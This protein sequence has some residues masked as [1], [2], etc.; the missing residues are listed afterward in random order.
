MAYFKFKEL[1]KYFDFTGELDINS[2]PDYVKDYV[3]DD[4][5]III[6]YKTRRDK[7]V[8]TDKAIILFDLVPIG[9]K[10]KIHKVPYRSISSGAVSF[11]KRSATI[12]FSLDSGYQLCLTFINLTSAG[13]SNVRMLYTMIM[14]EVMNKWY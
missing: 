1:S 12:E 5:K 4:E 14:G 13:K 9:I 11:K 10:K 7:G 6:A 3:R 8:F 2:L